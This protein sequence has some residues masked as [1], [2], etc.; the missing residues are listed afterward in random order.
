MIVVVSRVHLASRVVSNLAR[1]ERQGLGVDPDH[2]AP[3]LTILGSRF[4]LR[5]PAHHFLITNRPHRVVCS[6][7]SDLESL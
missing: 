3:A 5:C 2:F 6:R 1:K 7:D 4:H